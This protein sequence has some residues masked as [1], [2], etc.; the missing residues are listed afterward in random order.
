MGG[1][2]SGGGRQAA[3]AI[4]EA[5]MRRIVLIGSISTAVIVVGLIGFAWLNENV[6]L[7]QKTLVSVNGEDVSVAEFQERVE[8]DYF[9]QTG[10]QVTQ[11]G[12]DASF[13]GQSTYD[14]LIQ[15]ILVREKAE[16]LGI[17]VSEGDI[18]EEAELAFGYD[19]GEPEPTFTPFPTR[20]PTGTAT[21][22][23][24]FVLTPTNTLTPTLDPENSPTPTATAS[25]TPDGP[26]TATL[27]P[28]ITTEPTEITLE[29]FNGAID[30]L[31][32]VFTLNT[33]LPEDVILELYRER[34]ANAVYRRRLFEE[35]D[36]EVPT[37]QREARVQHI[38]VGT[39]EEAEDILAQLED[40]AD[41]GELAAEYSLDSSNAYRGGDLGWVRPGQ[42][43]EPFEA[44]ALGLPAGEISEPVET[45]FGWHIVKVNDV[46]EVEIDPFSYQQSQLQE[47]NAYLMELREEAE[48]VEEEDWLQYLPV[49][50]GVP[51][52]S[53]PLPGVPIPQ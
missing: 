5:R 20:E 48:V 37:V 35:L 13:F 26:P 3:R 11:P 41:F 28:T 16:E 8:F 46:A 45:T 14:S 19:S 30:N 33:S 53:A 36:L 32:E 47:F 18:D 50:P 10:G 21:M 39:E 4:R 34:V 7:P 52:P 1:R 9:F 23:P 27:T 2:R 24:T 31:V 17:S 38:L 43:V 49:L 44:V 42:M 40:G 6:L 22:T 25:P 15:E 51:P 12:I 29:D